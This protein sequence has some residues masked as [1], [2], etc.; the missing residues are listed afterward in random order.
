MNII[1]KIID[2]QKEESWFKNWTLGTSALNAHSEDVYPSKATQ[3]FLLLRNDEIRWNNLPDTPEK[4]CV[5]RKK[6]SKMFCFIGCG[7]HNYRAIEEMRNNWLTHTQN[8]THDSP[9]VMR[10]TVLRNNWFIILFSIWMF[11]RL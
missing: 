11:G 4:I 3:S 10:T 7:W 9:K 2:V 1:R 6:F 5:F 8:T